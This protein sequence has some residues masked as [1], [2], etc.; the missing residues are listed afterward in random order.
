MGLLTAA[1]LLS[2]TLWANWWNPGAIAAVY[3]AIK[4]MA[5]IAAVLAGIVT[6]LGLAINLLGGA[7]QG[8]LFMIVGGITTAAAAY[9]SINA[10]GAQAIAQSASGQVNLT[11]AQT[12][13]NTSTQ[14]QS[15]ATG[16]GNLAGNLATNA[17]NAVSSQFIGGL[18]TMQAAD[19]AASSALTNVASSLTTP[20]I[21]GA[22]VP[23]L[24]GTTTGIAGT[25]VTST[26]H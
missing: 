26:M 13:E 19:T 25:A 6:V 8:N 4:W 1:G 21:S 20:Y 3:A 24:T 15:Q 10:A 17:P 5:G 22:L 2:L 18:Q 7:S 9:M 11:A 16:L 23:G 12:L 14:L